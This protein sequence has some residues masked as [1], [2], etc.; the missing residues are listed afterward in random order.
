MTR[1]QACE[2]APAGWVPVFAGVVVGSAVVSP[3]ALHGWFL[4]LDWVGGPELRLPPSMYGMGAVGA[5]VPLQLLV[6]GLGLVVGRPA[7]QW[8]PVAAFFPVAMWSAGRLVG[9]ER[10][11][12]RLAA[13]LLYAVNPFVFE[14]LGAGQ[15]FVLL[16]Y[17][18]LPAFA[19]SLLDANFSK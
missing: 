1:A 9:G 15:V 18:I 17:A 13:G 10:V 4:L 8:L 11:T 6:D 3:L 16:G 2:W 14:R 7:M 12:P 19:R 5:S